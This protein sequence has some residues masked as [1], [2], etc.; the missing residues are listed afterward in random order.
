MKEKKRSRLLSYGTGY[1]V[2]G[3][4]IQIFQC[5]AEVRA[6]GEPRNNETLKP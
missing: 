4:S 6:E 1:E 5:V 3:V 2:F